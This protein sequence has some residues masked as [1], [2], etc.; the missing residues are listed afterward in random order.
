MI[1]PGEGDAQRRKSDHH[2]ADRKP[3]ALCPNDAFPST[4]R[5]NHGIPSM[6]DYHTHMELRSHPDV[7]PRAA[8]SAVAH[9]LRTSPVAVVLGARQTGKTTL[10][11]SLPQ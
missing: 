7:L 3:H 4:E 5:R 1:V 10:V 11:R 8:S 6:Y 9:A 2:H